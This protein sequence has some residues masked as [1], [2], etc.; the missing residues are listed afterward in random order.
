MVTSQLL[1][2][3]AS[4][5]DA[6]II[7]RF[8]N[9]GLV[10]LFWERQADGRIAGCEVTGTLLRQRIAGVLGQTATESRI[11]TILD[12]NGTPLAAPPGRPPVTGGARSSPVRSVRVSLGGKPPPI[13]RIPTP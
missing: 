13:S 1:S 10:F 12:E 4:A 3:I 6:G 7:P 2:Q 5:G 11:L 8:T 9:S